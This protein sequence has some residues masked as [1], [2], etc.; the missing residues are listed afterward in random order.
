[1]RVHAR[2]IHSLNGSQ[3]NIHDGPVIYWMSREQRVQDN[4]GLLYARELAGATQPLV[5]CFAMSPSFMCASFR[6]YDFMLKG[7]KEVADNLEKFSIPFTLR[8]GAP[9]CEIVRLANDIRAGVVV[10]DFD[11]L[12][13]V[14][15]W[16]KSA[17][18]EL[19][20]PLIEVDGRNIVPARI[21]SDKQEYAARTIR[22]KIHRLL[23]EYL[24]EFPKLIPQSVSLPEI[25]TPDWNG[26]Y[27]AVNVDR[28]I[29][30]VELAS[31][32]NAAHK[33]L[34]SFLKSRLKNYAEKSNDPNGESTSVLSPYIQFGQLS[35]QR[36]ALDVAATG[37]GESQD[38]FL[39]QLIVRRE[40]SDNFC[41]YNSD[42]DSL[43]GA[44][45]WAV[46]TL[47]DHMDDKR[48]YTYTLE[49]FDRAETHSHLWN[50][51]QNQMRKTGYMHGYMRMY[52][53]K[54]I[55][56]WSISPEQALKTVITLNDRYQLDGRSPNG[57]VGSLWSVAG[58]HDRP[59]K[60]RPVYGAIRYMN[61][62][63]CR[64]KFKVDE[65]ISRWI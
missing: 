46:A 40:L 47:D 55:L 62:R 28:S 32:E 20:V 63:G 27:R 56:E 64:R 11:P 37:A 41:L 53:A 45:D 6:Q 3:P 5:V 54:K 33:T 9:D 36:I 4:W 34:A 61:E 14:Q 31:G 42:Y 35:A 7:L 60:K 39:E 2:R 18:G 30:P 44:P 65:Y 38:K 23:F 25:A 15:G 8:I 21:V 50:G 22:P 17:A 24:E 51:A 57:Y 59:W 12:R 29:L 19:K 26:A 13:N 49:D 10:T 48:S 52:W 1:M 58:L 43:N 16:Q